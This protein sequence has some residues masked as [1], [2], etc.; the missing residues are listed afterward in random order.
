[1]FIQYSHLVL[2]VVYVLE[3]RSCIRMRCALGHRRYLY[4]GQD[5]VKF[6]P[7]I[8]ARLVKDQKTDT[9]VIESMAHAHVKL[10][11]KRR[12]ADL[13]RQPLGYQQM[14]P[15]VWWALLGLLDEMCMDFDSNGDLT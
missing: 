12:D 10:I 15:Q 5:P 3:A 8:V 11:E 4:L 2:C 7:E 9:D 1:M 6:V 13:R 14:H